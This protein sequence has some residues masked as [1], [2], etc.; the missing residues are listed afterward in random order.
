MK[1][2]LIARKNSFT[3]SPIGQKVLLSKQKKELQQ[4]GWK[5]LKNF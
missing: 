4:C 1:F 2:N 3:I 5:V